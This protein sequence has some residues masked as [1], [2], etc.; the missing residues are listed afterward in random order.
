MGDVRCA[1]DGWKGS[2]RQRLDGFD[3]QQIFFF[4][5]NFRA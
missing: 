4:L 3:V 1:L 2:S 5:S